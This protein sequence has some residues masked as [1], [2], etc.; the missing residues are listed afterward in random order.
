MTNKETS[1][2]FQARENPMD[3]E[4]PKKLP[5]AKKEDRPSVGAWGDLDA[6][7]EYRK[8]RDA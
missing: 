1:T 7:P 6:Y 3:A 5:Q 8:K 2:N 4:T